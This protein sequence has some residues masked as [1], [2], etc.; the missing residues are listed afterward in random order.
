MS[1][2]DIVVLLARDTVGVFERPG[3]GEMMPT[4]IVKTNEVVL[5]AGVV[6]Y[7]GTEKEVMV[8]TPRG[9]WGWHYARIFKHLDGTAT[10]FSE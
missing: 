3:D 9:L 4:D 7:R 6:H 8:I 5:V 1:P 10:S 2:G